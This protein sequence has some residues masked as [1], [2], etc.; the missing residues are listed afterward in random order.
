MKIFKNWKLTDDSKIS[1][2]YAW[3]DGTRGIYGQCLPG[4]FTDIADKPAD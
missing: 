1:I 4:Y 3:I 2:D